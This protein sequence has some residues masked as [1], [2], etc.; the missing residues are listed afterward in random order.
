VNK[1]GTGVAVDASTIDDFAR[2][3]GPVAYA[4]VILSISTSEVVY[5]R[6]QSTK[7]VIAFAEW[8]SH[9]RESSSV[10]VLA[11]ELSGTINRGGH[12]SAANAAAEW[13][14]NIEV[15]GTGS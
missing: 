12:Y 10:G 11:Y 2:E 13:R 7:V 14:L 15:E 5:L 3:I 8:A 1:R 6:E 9:F 4:A